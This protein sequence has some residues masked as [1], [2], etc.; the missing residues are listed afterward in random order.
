MDV[1]VQWTSALVLLVQLSINLSCFM[2]GDGIMASFRKTVQKEMFSSQNNN[3]VYFN[4]AL[5]KHLDY[6]LNSLSACYSN[7]KFS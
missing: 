4:M 5:P 6:T 3:S 7:I 1:C 2:S